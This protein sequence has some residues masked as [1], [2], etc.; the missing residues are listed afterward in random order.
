MSYITANDEEP[1]EDSFD[2]PHVRRR[3]PIKETL[4][5]CPKCFSPSKM[6]PGFL[7]ASSYSCENPE[8]SWTG[9]LAI[10]VDRE[11]YKEFL[12]KQARQSSK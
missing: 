3:R 5:V 6:T 12:E 4:T 9:T 7:I 11:E 2:E 1:L 8:C 10:E